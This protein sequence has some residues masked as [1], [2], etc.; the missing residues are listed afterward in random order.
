MKDRKPKVI[1]RWLQDQKILVNP[2]GQVLP[3]CYMGNPAYVHEATKHT[4]SPGGQQFAKNPVLKK[5]LDNKEE[6]NLNHKTISEIL[7]SDWFNKDLPESWKEYA[8]I[9][10]MCQ[11]FC[12][13]Q[14]DDVV[15]ED[16]WQ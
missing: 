12:D 13:N 2:D 5:Y 6:Y 7:T 11:T 8:T 10:T 16:P 14:E 3:C 4:N 1:C 15:F 9:P